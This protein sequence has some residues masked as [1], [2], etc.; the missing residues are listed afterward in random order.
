MFNVKAQ[1]TLEGL[2]Q[3][4]YKVEELDTMGFTLKEFTADTNCASQIA[5]NSAQFAVGI[6]SRDETCSFDAEDF[7]TTAAD[8]HLQADYVNVTA[9]NN[10][11]RSD[12]KLTDTDAV[13][14]QFVIHE[15]AN[16]TTDVDN[17]S[18]T[19]VRK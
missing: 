16:S 13:K 14:N 4:I 19:D 8:L 12:G 17:H 6:R 9:K 15:K 7:V 10:K 3:G 18:T 1:T 5:G 2:A 11:T